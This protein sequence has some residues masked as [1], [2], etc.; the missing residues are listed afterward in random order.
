MN[1]SPVEVDPVHKTLTVPCTA[2]EAF[3]MFTAEMAEWWPL[4]THGV[5]HEEAVTVVVEPGVGG[6]IVEHGPGGATSVWGV[7]TAW[8]PGRRVAFTWYPGNGE[9]DATDVDVSFTGVGGGTRVDLVHTGW[10]RRPDGAAVRE[11][12]VPGWD[13]VLGRYVA[14]VTRR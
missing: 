13:F 2:E 1:R 12:Y 10:D 4:E 5:Y 6:R 11:M 14:G 9:D 7:V 8:E 3:R